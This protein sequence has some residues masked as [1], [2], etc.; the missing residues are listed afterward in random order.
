MTSIVAERKQYS[1]VL[2][3]DFNPLMFQP[4]WFGRNDVISME[5]VEFARNPNNSLQTIIVPA[6]TLFRTSQLSVKVEPD[7]FQILAEKEPWIT[8]KDFVKKTF[9][10]LGGLTIRAYGFNYSAHYRFNGVSEMHAFADKL[11]PK[12]YWKTLLGNDVTG[13]DRKGG[14]LSLQMFQSKENNEGYVTV[15]LQDSR[16]VKPGIFL[17]CNDHVSISEDDSSAEIVMEK[18]ENTFDI[19]FANMARIQNDLI[20]ETMKDE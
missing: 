17:T 20:T 5:D 13:D 11:T 8:V 1:I 4:E 14:L 19:S 9:E 7:R 16:H 6:F 10:K 3:G 18:I 15:L 12:L 2:L